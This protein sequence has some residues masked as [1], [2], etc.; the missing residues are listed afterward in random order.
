MP[1]P[2]VTSSEI[3][4]DR[5]LLRPSRVR[6]APRAGFAL[7]LGDQRSVVLRGGYGVFL[8]QWAYSVQT[9]FSR[10]LPFFFLK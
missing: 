5:S 7:L 8:N 3:G 10:N 2:W 6:L 4:W 9:A 1:I